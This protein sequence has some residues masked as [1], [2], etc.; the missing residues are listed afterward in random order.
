MTSDD[1]TEAPDPVV[2]LL[3]TLDLQPAGRASVHVE[4]PDDSPELDLGSGRVD[5]FEG[6][7]QPMPHGRV[8]GGQVLAQCLVAAGRTVA[9]GPAE[10]ARSV[11]SMHGYFLRPGD[12]TQPIRFAV[13]RMRDGRSFSARRVHALQDGKV[14]MSVILSFQDEASGLDH[15]AVMPAA[16][17]PERLPTTAQDIGDID[18]PI[19]QHWAYRRAVD[20]RHVENPIYIEPGAQAAANQ[21]V[22]MKVRD[23][24]PDDPLLHAAALAYGSDYTLLESAL[25]RHRLAWSDPRLRAASLDHAMWFHRPVRADEWVLYQQDSPSASGGRGLGMGKMFAADG[26]LVATVAQEGMLRVKE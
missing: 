7:S 11:H 22:W 15:Q 16:P 8:F 9:D 17:N 5:V 25:R 24:M 4:S 2:D 23:R 12:S 21:N 20:I 1:S 6:R 14:I 19:A 26:T 3:D 18:H 10:N 13:E